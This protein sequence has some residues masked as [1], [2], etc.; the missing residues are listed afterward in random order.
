MQEHKINMPN[1][2]RLSV[3][4]HPESEAIIEINTKPTPV[5]SIIKE[6]E[7]QQISELRSTIA[8]EYNQVTKTNTQPTSTTLT[9]NNIKS[10]WLEKLL[11]IKAKLKPEKKLVND[12]ATAWNSYYDEE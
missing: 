2:D 4:Q 6:A 11:K 10:S 9:P 12:P 7:E 1:L 8:N 5:S 3:S